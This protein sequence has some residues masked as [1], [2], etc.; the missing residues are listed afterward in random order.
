MSQREFYEKETKIY[1]Q[2][3]RDYV[4]K[5]KSAFPNYHGQ[6]NIE[7]E[8]KNNISKFIE[9]KDQYSIKLFPSGYCQ[10]IYNRLTRTLKFASKK[11]EY[12]KNRVIRHEMN[13]ALTRRMTN[14]RVTIR[15]VLLSE[16]FQRMEIGNRNLEEGM[17][18]Y[19]ACVMEGDESEKSFNGSPG[20]DRLLTIVN[21]LAK[22]YGQEVVLEYYLGENKNLINAINKTGK[23]NFNKVRYLCNQLEKEGTSPEL[24]K[25]IRCEEGK[26]KKYMEEDLLFRLFKENKM[27]PT[28]TIEDFKYN[29]QQLFDFYESDLHTLTEE[30][31]FYKTP[32]TDDKKSLYEYNLQVSI[33]KFKI[34]DNILK[35]EWKKLNRNDESEYKRLVNEQINKQNEEIKGV[36]KKYTDYDK[37]EVRSK[38][39]AKEEQSTQK[40]YKK[41]ETIQPQPPKTS[42]RVTTN[43]QE[44]ESMLKEL[45][46]ST[47]YI[48][49]QKR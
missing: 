7:K 17:T 35:Q 48:G 49:K 12:E 30:I 37:Q 24:F 32:P 19:V 18:E 9:Y 13:H 45:N 40:I 44:L 25:P 15:N 2:M 14:K 36:I 10:G 4:E 27:I 38:K 5:F 11:S 6:L 1:E 26:K 39:I 3:I 23:N 21:K 28:T 31:E 22:I 16:I 20:N 34:F 46:Q 33:K 43:N 41:K 42:H 29:L 47:E 8:L